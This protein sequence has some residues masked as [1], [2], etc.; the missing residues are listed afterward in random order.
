MTILKKGHRHCHEQYNV[1]AMIDYAIAA[2][3]V[4]NVSRMGET[5]GR[6]MAARYGKAGEALCHSSRAL[7]FK[8]PTKSTCNSALIRLD[9]ACMVYNRT[10]PALGDR[11]YAEVLFDASP[12][13]SREILAVRENILTFASAYPDAEPKITSRL[14]PPIILGHKHAT[15]PDKALA[16][17]QSLWL[18]RGPTESRLR[19][20]ALKVINFPTDSGPENQI[21]L[22]RDILPKFFDQLISQPHVR[23]FPRAMKWVG[24]N[25]HWDNA[26]R[27]IL[28]HVLDWYPAWV[29]S[30]KLVIRF[31]RYT[32]YVDVMVDILQE[33]CIA[34]LAGQ[35]RGKPPNLATWRWGTL[36][37]AGKA[38][39]RRKQALDIGFE[40]TRFDLTKDQPKAMYHALLPGDPERFWMKL[41]F[42]LLLFVPLEDARAWGTGCVHP[43]HEELRRQGK[44]VVCELVGR[45]AKEAWRRV[46]QAQREMQHNSD[47]VI[48][49]FPGADVMHDGFMQASLALR[50][51]VYTRWRHLDGLPYK[52]VRA[53]EPEIMQ[54]CLDQAARLGNDKLDTISAL[55]FAGSSTLL[56]Q[57]VTLATTGVCGEA[58][59]AA[60]LPY[61][62]L[63][64]DESSIE[65]VHR[66]LN[67]LS[68]SP[69]MGFAGAVA[70]LRKHQNARDVDEARKCPET[71][72]LFERAWRNWKLTSQCPA[73]AQNVR[74][75]VPRSTP[76]D[77]KSIRP[78]D[79]IR[80]AFKL[81]R[82]CLQDHSALKSM[83]KD[84]SALPHTS[85][86]VTT[87]L[88]IDWIRAATRE[89]G[90]FSVAIDDDEESWP[91][92]AVL[93]EV[94]LSLVPRTALVE[95][96]TETDHA[97]RFFFTLLRAR[98]F[99]DKETHTD[100]RRVGRNDL[101]VQQLERWRPRADGG[102]DV[103]EVFI[104]ADPCFCDA[105]AIAPYISWRNSLR[106]W[107]G[108]GPSDVGGCYKYRKGELAVPLVE[109]VLNIP[110]L[111]AL[112]Q[113]AALE[114]QVTRSEHELHSSTADLRL[115]LQDGW[116]R[117]PLYLSC[118][119]V[120]D[121]LLVAGLPGLMPAQLQSYYRA[122][123]T[124]ADKS[125]VEPGK[126]HRTYMLMLKDKDVPR[127]AC[128]DG[129]H[130]ALVDAPLAVAA[131]E[132]SD[133]EPLQLQDDRAEPMDED[134]ELSDGSFEALHENVYAA[135]VLPKAKAAAPPVVPPPPC[136][137]GSVRLLELARLDSA[138]TASGLPEYVSGIRV[139]REARLWQGNNMYSR[140]RV[141]CPYHP[142]CNASR[143]LSYSSNFGMAQVY[144]YLGAWLQGGAPGSAHS[145]REAHKLFRPDVGAIRNFLD[146]VHLL[147]AGS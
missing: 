72:L 63:L 119:L 73:H 85:P 7:N 23:L 8:D 36:I 53:R 9:H 77:V 62:W 140:R 47:N 137:P 118:L 71:R 132:D 6:F 66:R 10:C 131:G 136:A 19:G 46:Q 30:F 41:D 49:L 16:F 130:S 22:C 125:A 139:M 5:F 100:L 145:S 18:V 122:A 80:K 96:S 87:A 101:L 110:A 115:C 21:A 43:E 44:K 42:I 95:D 143:S 28:T 108:D 116:Q 98:P 60:L 97:G 114:W 103:A 59:S 75:G 31:C 27:Y 127:V 11:S 113:L 93:D 26:L 121:S 82:S 79:A 105:L 89:G 88:A 135:V 92:H 129:G 25:H 86:A 40:A 1:W 94:Q 123:L 32:S 126:S 76:A 54:Q 51:A 112:E 37:Q 74:C 39:K 33:K 142:H 52:I 138:Y 111:A 102:E 81:D 64:I 34:G 99:F 147:P 24:W 56:P 120:L 141:T 20:Y 146:S 55:F 69:G 17:L 48:A 107:L 29:N 90:V 2:D 117:A 14:L 50:G 58:L 104:G 61:E 4:H 3:A 133:F 83:L 70:R 128:V 38:L 134:T 109:D 67:M 68:D 15:G 78:S 13:Q 35:L 12:F 45:R 144:G 57:C 91:V 65:E 84:I 124:L 106:N